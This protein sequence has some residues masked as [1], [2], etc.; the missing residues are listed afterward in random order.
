M[1][2]KHS[3]HKNHRFQEIRRNGSSV[4]NKIIVVCVDNNH[5]AYSRFGFSVSKR[6]GNAVV[7]NRIKRRL[8]EAVRQR[9]NEIRTGKDIVFIARFPIKYADYQEID[10]SCARLLRRANLLI[11]QS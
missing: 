3:V 5:L 9:I 6:I 11:V 4:S 10:K 1:K 7:R 2:R 8:K